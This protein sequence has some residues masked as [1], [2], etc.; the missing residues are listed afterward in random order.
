MGG[1]DFDAGKLGTASP[2]K[3]YDLSTTLKTNGGGM[4]KGKR[5]HQPEKGGASAGPLISDKHQI[6]ALVRALLRLRWCTL[7]LPVLMNYISRAASLRA[8]YTRTST[9]L[10]STCRPSSRFPR[11]SARSCQA[12]TRS[13]RLR[14]TRT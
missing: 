11:A 9:K 13:T 3:F 2:A 12:R 4:P 14:P 8:P 5:W 1:G 10:V 6:E 7:D